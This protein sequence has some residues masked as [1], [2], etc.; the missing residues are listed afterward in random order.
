[1]RPQIPHQLQE[2]AEE[3]AGEHGF[4]SASELIRHAVRR[5]LDDLDH[6]RE[7]DGDRIICSDCG[8]ELGTVEWNEETAIRND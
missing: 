8:T 1:M 5:Q 4:S 6:S 7:I 3:A 2:R